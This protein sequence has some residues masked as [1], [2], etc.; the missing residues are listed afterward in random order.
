MLV[1]IREGNRSFSAKSDWFLSD[2]LMDWS[3]DRL[4]VSLSQR[5]F[6]MLM[7]ARE[8]KTLSHLSRTERFGKVN[9]DCNVRMSLWP[10]ISTC[11][12]WSISARNSV[13]SSFHTLHTCLLLSTSGRS[14]GTSEQRNIPSGIWEK[15]FHFVFFFSGFKGLMKSLLNKLELLRGRMASAGDARPHADRIIKRPVCRDFQH[16]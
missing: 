14:L 9:F 8:I 16:L 10:F 12:V 7:S 11:E 5:T 3:L 15:Y 1:G 13:F 2:W 4:N 6:V